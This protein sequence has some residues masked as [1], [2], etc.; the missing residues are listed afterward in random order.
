MAGRQRAAATADDGTALG[1]AAGEADAVIRAARYYARKEGAHLLIRPAAEPQRPKVIS[2]PLALLPPASIAGELLYAKIE[3]EAGGQPALLISATAASAAG[4]WPSRLRRPSARWR[5]LG[6]RAPALLLGWLWNQSMRRRRRK[7]GKVSAETMPAARK[8]GAGSDLPTGPPAI[9]FG[10]HWLDI[11]GAEAFALDCI[12]A[13]A[14]HA[15]VIVTTDR[16]STHPL[17]AT[18]SAHSNVELVHIDRHVPEGMETALFEGIVARRNVRV[19]HIHHSEAL[20]RALPALKASHPSLAVLD[21]LHIAEHDGGFPALARAHD[22]FI[23][24]HH[25]VSAGLA[26]QMREHPGA[27]PVEVGALTRGTVPKAVPNVLDARRAGHPVR[28]AFVGRMV[29]QK[30]PLLFVLAAEAIARRL[31]QEGHDA[32]FLMLGEGPELETV[33]ALVAHRGLR[34]R[35]RFFPADHSVPDLLAPADV[36]LL[37]SEN[38]GLALVSFEALGAGAFALSAN[39]G[40]QHEITPGALLL[41]PEPGRLPA[42][43]AEIVAKLLADPSFAGDAWRQAVDLHDTV[44]RHREGLEVA[45]AFYARAG[46]GVAPKAVFAE[47]RVRPR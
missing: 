19:I 42:A 39:V 43:A 33:K 9:L 27:P 31:Q 34:S 18:L 12:H 17:A 8:A 1:L 29:R 44:R 23:D 16:S 46:I 41:P 32:E 7:R 20:Y 37:P 4:N 26:G 22:A 2:A 47:T 30:R 15:Q 3:P 25:V 14:E 28:I 11:G 13:A 35:F 40:A 5:W 21:S 6:T 45:L 38:E 36:L 10:L 24:L